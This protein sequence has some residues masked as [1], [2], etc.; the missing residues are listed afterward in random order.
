MR[1]KYPGL[2]GL[3]GQGG[4]SEEDGRGELQENL[5]ERQCMVSYLRKGSSAVS[6]P[7]HQKTKVCSSKF[8]P[9]WEWRGCVHICLQS[10]EL[11]KQTCCQIF[12]L[13][14]VL[15]YSFPSLLPDTSKL[16]KLVLE[17]KLSSKAKMPF[18]I[19]KYHSVGKEHVLG[20]VWRGVQKIKLG[21]SLLKLDVFT[22]PSLLTGE[23]GEERT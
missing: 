11:A 3:N 1:G 7:C 4:Q 21:Q 19:L 18:Y 23:G 2:K 14:S 12:V 17:K 16:L 15:V 9:Y 13:F 22:L 10:L 6:S 5:R 8:T 20:R